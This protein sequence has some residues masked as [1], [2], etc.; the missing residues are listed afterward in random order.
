LGAG[1]KGGADRRRVHVLTTVEGGNAAV[2]LRLEVGEL[3]RS[4]AL[5]FFEE[6]EGLPDDL[7][8]GGVAPRLHLVGDKRF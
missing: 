2:E 3:G 4:N 8:G 5:V 7:A 1:P 6:A